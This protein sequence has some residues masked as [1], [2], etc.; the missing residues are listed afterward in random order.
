MSEGPGSQWQ[1]PREKE[2][3]REGDRQTELG[4]MDRLGVGG[5]LPEKRQ[6]LQHLG[7]ERNRPSMGVCGRSLNSHVVN[8]PHVESLRT[9]LERLL[10]LSCYSSE[11]IRTLR[12]VVFV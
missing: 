5:L 10:E 12:P 11:G 8:V 2:R 9:R 6:V 4:E 7:G 3:V 1:T